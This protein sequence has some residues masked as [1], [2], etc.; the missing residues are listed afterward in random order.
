M[1]SAKPSA[2]SRAVEVALRSKV[3]AQAVFKF[4][5]ANSTAETP[6]LGVTL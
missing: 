4:V 3:S 2:L 6:M 5:A 1:A